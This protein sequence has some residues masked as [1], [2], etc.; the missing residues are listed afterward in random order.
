LT[1]DNLLYVLVGLLLGFV[2]GFLLQEAMAVRQSQRLL[3]AQAAALAAQGA[4]GNADGVPPMPNDARVAPMP[5]SGPAG[6]LGAA[7]QPGAGG[8]GGAGGAG[9]AQG[10]PGP[11]MEQV[12]QLQ[13]RIDKNPKDAEALVG[14]ANMNFDIKNWARARELYERYLALH[15]PDP[16]TLSDLGVCYRG[17]GEY[18]KALDMFRKARQLAPDHWQ[19]L[20]NEVVVLTF[21]LRQM[22]QA[23]TAL[24]QLEKMQPGN[25]DV[26]QLATEV[27]K[28]ANASS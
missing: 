8:V 17:L 16:D 1:K 13:A 15:A 27:R 12:R 25:P 4:P 24:Q 7:P 3:P 18:P 26:Q 19:S 23:Q 9:A 5:E 10:A 20:F 21:N 14:L 2:A 22:D 28:Q 6:V 11:V